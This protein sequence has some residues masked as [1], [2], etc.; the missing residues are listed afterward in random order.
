MKFRSNTLY[1]FSPPVMLATLLIEVG[2]ALYTLWRYGLTP[3]SR[4]V[5]AMLL[6]LA[7][8]QGAEYM[9]CGGLGIQPG[10]WSKIGYSAITLLPP[11][12]I[13]LVTQISGK[14]RPMLVGAAYASS[15]AF[16]VYFA[17]ITGAISGQTCYANYVVFDTPNSLVGNLYGLYYYGWL[18]VAIGLSLLPGK[19]KKHQRQALGWLAA[20]YSAFLIPTTT[21]NLIDPSTISGIPSIMCGFA[22]ILAFALTLKVM[23]TASKH[24]S[25]MS[26]IV[27][28]FSRS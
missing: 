5:V 8:F 28:L 25:P 10:L 4:L 24:A 27:R 23:P 12:G 13:H 19:V 9:I 1:C 16:L 2:F 18:V 3:L 7:T 15:I 14:K 11:L 21:V 17:F 6:C 26:K 22:V 20:G